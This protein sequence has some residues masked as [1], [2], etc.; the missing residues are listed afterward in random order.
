MADHLQGCILEEQF[1]VMQK[2]E[3]FSTG[4]ATGT[5]GTFTNGPEV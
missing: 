3:D 2:D 5:E 4:Q 1:V